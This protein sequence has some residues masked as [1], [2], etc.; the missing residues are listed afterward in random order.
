MDPHKGYVELIAGFH[1]VFRFFHIEYV[2][3]LTYLNLPTATKQ[4]IRV[5]FSMK[6]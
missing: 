6:F 3:R 1:N 2:R 5:K 4:G